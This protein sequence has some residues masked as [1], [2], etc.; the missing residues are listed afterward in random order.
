MQDAGFA[1]RRARYV[2]LVG[3]TAWYVKGYI[4]R[5]RDLNA[6]LVNVQALLFDGIA[7]PALR[8]LESMFPAPFG[9]SLVIIDQAA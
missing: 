6:E 2:N 5:I 9:Q 7:V 1:I 3:A 4:L 8:R